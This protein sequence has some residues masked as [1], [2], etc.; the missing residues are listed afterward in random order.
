M[1]P[2]E[3]RLLVL[4]AFRYKCGLLDCL[5]DYGPQVH[6]IK[7]RSH[8][9]ELL[10]YNQIVLCAEHHQRVHSEGAIRWTARL[11]EAQE[12]TLTLYGE[13]TLLTQIRE[14]RE[15]EDQSLRHRPTARRAR[16]SPLPH[17]RTHPGQTVRSKT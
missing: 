1:T 3:A 12:R 4:E 14:R 13:E 10:P 11:L 9:G 5:S 15:R 2:D 17:P 16:C 7:P 8:G 6:E